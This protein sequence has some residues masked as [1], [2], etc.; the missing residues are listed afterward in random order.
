MSDDT[1]VVENEEEKDTPI[2]EVQ[3]GLTHEQV[4]SHYKGL[5]AEAI[6]TRD[7]A[8]VALR[9]TR[10]EL[11]AARAALE[12]S[13]TLEGELT[14]L[15]TTIKT[16]SI[17]GALSNALKEAGALSVDTA[18]KLIDFNQVEVDDQYNPNPEK[19]KA[20]I[21]G[22]KTSDAILFK[23]PDTATPTNP[24]P[25]LKVARPGAGQD[26]DPFIKELRAAKNEKEIEA[27]RIKY[28]R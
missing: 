15:K 1:K 21:E 6:S 19:L 20:L 4:A 5:M 22:L 2:V 8:K 24:V 16:N 28:G 13:K 17:K 14:T 18:L 26:G 12:K 10:K 25:G 9:E 27:V 11:E 3:P 23:T 7:K